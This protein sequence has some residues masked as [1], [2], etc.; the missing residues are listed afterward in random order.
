MAR[1]SRR[2]KGCVSRDR[3][4]PRPRRQPSPETSITPEDRRHPQDSRGARPPQTPRFWTAIAGV[5][6]GQRPVFDEDSLVLITNPITLGSVHRTRS[7]TRPP[8]K[9]VSGTLRS[10][11]YKPAASALPSWLARRLL[12]LKDIARKREEAKHQKDTEPDIDPR[13]KHRVVRFSDTVRV[14][15]LVVWE[16]A[17]RQARRGTWLQ[18]SADRARFQRRITEAE[19]TIGSC[20]TLEARAKAWARRSLAE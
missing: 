9:A 19:A 18:D 4:G 8:S 12:S 11:A 20:L 7:I 6:A 3:V 14:H 16:S 17:A 5:G 1:K 10:P 13:G 15:R 2:R